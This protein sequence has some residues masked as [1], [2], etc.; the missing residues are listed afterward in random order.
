MYTLSHKNFFKRFK[1]EKLDDGTKTKAI[2]KQFPQAS[3]TSLPNTFRNQEE[4]W[5]E[6]ERGLSGEGTL[7]KGQ[8]LYRQELR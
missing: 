2:I 1:T 5:A 3:P 7:T 4:R 8:A 6:S